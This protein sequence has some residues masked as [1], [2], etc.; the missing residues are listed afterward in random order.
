MREFGLTFEQATHRPWDSFWTMDDAAIAFSLMYTQHGTD[1]NREIGT[2][3]YSVRTGF[4]GNRRT[5]YTFGL[6]WVG[7]EY[8]VALGLAGRVTID[9]WEW[10]RPLRSSVAALAHTHPADINWFSQE[11]RN[12]AHGRYSFLGLGISAMP[13]FMSVMMDGGLEIRRFDNS[14]DR[15]ARAQ[16]YG[17]LILSR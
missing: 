2:M 11:D 7:G 4:R 9:A 5:H 3:I 12:L 10:G 15:T 14:M 13:V 16:R 17:R 6:P 1:I 8:D